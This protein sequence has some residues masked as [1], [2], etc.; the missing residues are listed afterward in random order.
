MKITKFTIQSNQHH[1]FTMYT[2]SS[3]VK[4]YTMAFLLNKLLKI[5]L[6]RQDDLPVY[7]NLK[8]PTIWSLYFFKKDHLTEYYLI[9]NLEEQNQLMNN[10]LLIIQGHTYEDDI[11]MNMI[12]KSREILDINRIFLH[13]SSK[14]K[15]DKTV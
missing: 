14:T 15:T 3:A 10:F 5:N 8:S 11:F 9:Q 6:T 2:L 13:D 1:D 4:D 12:G 7:I